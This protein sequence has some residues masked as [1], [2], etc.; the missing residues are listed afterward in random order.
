MSDRDCIINQQLTKG[1]VEVY[2]DRETCTYRLFTYQNEIDLCSVDFT[3]KE[4]GT[5]N[6]QLAVVLEK[7]GNTRHRHLERDE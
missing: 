6:K 4:L 5:F 1:W 7:Y 2:L 3:F